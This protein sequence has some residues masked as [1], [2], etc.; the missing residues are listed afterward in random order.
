MAMVSPCS[1]SAFA[2]VSTTANLG[3]TLDAWGPWSTSFR[4]R[5]FGPRPLIEDNSV[6]SA[7]S[8]VGNLRVA[9]R[10][11]ARNRLSLDV[12]NLFNTRSND[13]DYF[14]ASRLAGEPAPVW[15]RHVHPAEPRMLRL[16]WSHRFD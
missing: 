8:W 3:I 1:L 14:Y 5:Y 2:T 4:L 16:S 6:K 12:F 13:I 7:P 9:Y 11:D 10:V 15:D